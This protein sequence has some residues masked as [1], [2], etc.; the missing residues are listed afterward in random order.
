MSITILGQ[1]IRLIRP[2]KI[3]VPK[4]YKDE[5]PQIKY[6]KRSRTI[7]EHTGRVV[8]IVVKLKSGGIRGIRNR[9]KTHADVIE[10]FDIIPEFVEKVGWELDNGNFV[11]R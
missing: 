6:N 4:I 8:S 1:H 3:P 10:L 11:W 2:E 5:L 7:K 9:C